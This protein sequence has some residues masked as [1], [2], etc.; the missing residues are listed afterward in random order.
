[1]SC[2]LWTTNRSEELVTCSSRWLTFLTHV[3]RHADI[4]LDLSVIALAFVIYGVLF[5][6]LGKAFLPGH[7]AWSTL[8]LWASAVVGAYIA[9]L[10]FLPRVIGMLVAGLL[11]QNI[12]WSA[13]D[14]FPEKWG[15]QM[16]A[17]ALATIFLRC[18]LELSLPSM[19]RYKFP[20]MRLAVIPGVLEAV[21][22]AGLG[23]AFFGMSY[24]LGLTMGFILKAVGPGLIVPEMFKLQR[25]GLGTDQG[26]PSVILIAASFD[27]ILAITG[28]AIFSTIAITPDSSASESE[29]AAWSIASGPVQVFIGVF[30]GILG[31]VIIAITK[32]WNTQLKRFLILYFSGLFIMFFLEYWELLSGGALGALFTS[33]IGSNLWEKGLPKWGSLGPSLVFSPDCERWMSLIWRWIMEPILFATVGAILDFNDLDS[34]TIP[35]AIAIVCSG[36]AVRMVLTYLAMAGMRYNVK[37]KIFFSVAWT[38]K[39]TVQAALSAAPLTLIQ[40]YKSGSPDYDEWIAW[41]NDI[42][43]T[44][45]FAIIICGTCGS[46]AVHFLSPLL[47]K[48]SAAAQK[49]SQ[50]LHDSSPERRSTYDEAGDVNFEMVGNQWGTSSSRKRI[51][52]AVSTNDAVQPLSEY[53]SIERTK[54]ADNI[55]PLTVHSGLESLLPGKDLI[56]VSEYIDAIEH[57]TNAVHA[58][59]TQ[60]S[61]EEIQRLSKHVIF[62]Q[63]VSAAA[64]ISDYIFFKYA[65]FYQPLYCRELNTK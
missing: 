37:E 14:S 45:L 48:K 30:A 5:F 36:L 19:K 16:R 60:V 23:V 7:P 41:G 35:K 26:I 61:R 56:I 38:P 6:G 43:T 53:V 58:G 3:A 24:L 8:L 52:R 21:F 22:D 57:L 50:D 51:P 59:E 1:M 62:I 33:L 15:I 9:H 11:L 20:A 31:G 64:L 65:I 46:A 25:Q 47:L 29:N 13:I 54:S 32:V 63:K 10:L 40:K 55:T 18:G 17:A 2:V 34:G 28:Y 27:D 4:Y 42:L 39:A 44:G 49:K 12:P